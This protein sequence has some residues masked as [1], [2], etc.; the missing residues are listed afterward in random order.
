[1]S[2]AETKVPAIGSLNGITDPAVR[3]V[4]AAMKE[5]LEVRD[6][7]RG[8]ALDRFVTLRELDTAGVVSVRNPSLGGKL[9]VLSGDGGLD[10]STPPALTNFSVTGGYAQIFLSWDEPQY[11]SFAY[12][13]IW[14]SATDAIGTADLIG[15]TPAA[16]YSDS[17]GTQASF[18]YWVRAVSEAGVVGPYHAVSGAFGATS[19]D[20]EYLIDQLTESMPDDPN[21]Q[22]FEVKE[23]TTITQADGTQVLVPAGVYIK[24]ARIAKASITNAQIGNA[25]I[26]NAKIANL[27]AAKINAGTIASA[28]LDSDIITAKALYAD[29][30]AIKQAV[31]KDAHIDTLNANKINAGFISAARIAA[32]SITADKLNVSSLDAVSATIGVLRTRASGARMEIR[33]DVIKVF[34]SNNIVRV[35]LGNLG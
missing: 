2:E 8:K 20:V 16:V 4:L 3:T 26:D 18:Y 11:A 33:D 14:R 23:A 21:R 29:N 19:E 7:R 17:C 25:Q 22:L 15:Q 1:M 6:G 10:Y 28:R 24:S 27:N 31:I 35:Q 30:A 13:E 32:D 34:D 9:E 5:L 12:V